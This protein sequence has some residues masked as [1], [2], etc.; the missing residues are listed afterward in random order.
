MIPIYD[1]AA[2]VIETHERAALAKSRE[3]FVGIRSDPLSTIFRLAPA[4]TGR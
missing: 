2:H 4:G 3:Q 1:A